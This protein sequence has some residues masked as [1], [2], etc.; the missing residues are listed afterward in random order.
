MIFDSNGKLLPV[1]ANIWQVVA[2]KLNMGVKNLYFI[3]FQERGVNIQFIR[4]NAII[5]RQI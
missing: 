2:K 3:V 5:T 1:K 4:E